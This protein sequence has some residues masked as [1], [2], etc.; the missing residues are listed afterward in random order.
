MR[1]LGNLP[2]SMYG[3]GAGTTTPAQPLSPEG[4]GKSLRSP[5]MSMSGITKPIGPAGA[6]KNKTQV[7][8]T[9]VPD[10]NNSKLM[11]R[12]AEGAGKNK[13]QPMRGGVPLKGGGSATPRTKKKPNGGAKPDKPDGM[14]SPGNPYSTPKAAKKQGLTSRTYS[15]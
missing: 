11:P 3:R 15:M 13:N 2:P 6:P 9:G 5:D 4:R 7:K 10:G 1:G 12:T 14:L 8:L